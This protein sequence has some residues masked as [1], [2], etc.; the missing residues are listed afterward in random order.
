MGPWLDRL[1]ELTLI[2][3]KHISRRSES[4]IKIENLPLEVISISVFFLVQA[5]LL[6]N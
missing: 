5:E 1:R 6:N 4:H 3:R 2:K